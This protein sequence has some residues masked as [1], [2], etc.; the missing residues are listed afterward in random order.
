V[1]LLDGMRA[2]GVTPNVIS[3][4]AAISAC[5]KGRQWEKAVSLLDGMR[6][7]GVTPNVI[8]YSAAIQACAVAEQPATALRLFQQAQAAIEPNVVSYNAVLD[9]VRTQHAGD[10]RMLWLQGVADGHYA[11]FERQEGGQPVLDLHGFS[12][13]A[14]ET[15]VLWWLD[16]CMPAMQRPPNRVIIV[17]GWGK[18]RATIQHSDVRGHVGRVLDARGV[19]TVAT[20]NPGR[21]VVD[22]KAWRER[23]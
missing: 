21:V 19:P 11:N 8:S 23:E 13:G 5:E 1:S 6:A 9:A 2:A 14:A 16:E 3:Y 17:T 18:S 7:A 20:D 22:A 15:A 12:E 4:N 10:A